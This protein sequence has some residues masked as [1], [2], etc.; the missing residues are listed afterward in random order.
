[1][2]AYNIEK[3]ISASIQSVLNQTYTDWELIIIN[4]GS[5]DDTK[6]VIESFL[7]DSRIKYFEQSNKGASFARNN[8]LSHA[9]GNYIAFL[10]GDDL[11]DSTYLEK[12][13]IRHKQ[14][15]DIVY[16][17]HN[18]LNVDGKI[19]VNNVLPSC[20]GNILLYA[21]KNR[22][23]F[24]MG[25]V[26]F[27][28][29]FLVSN[30]LCF[31]ENCPVGEDFELIYKS[32]ALGSAQFIPENLMLYRKRPGSIT[33]SKWNN[34]TPLEGIHSFERTR[35]FITENYNDSDKREVLNALNNQTAESKCRFVWQ[36]IQ[37]GNYDEA[38]FYLL[39]Q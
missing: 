15:P 37:H 29:N 18:R 2:P 28:Q 38:K 31:A 3:Y 30:K 16:C 13:H 20:E 9:Q 4:D 14:S 22:G 39:E 23:V 8:G 32:L 7:N 6:Y 12:M 1:M 24:S 17:G 36:L 10:D 35:N 5:M 27:K 26:S 34:V 11:W 33:Q 25:T 21:L 19:E